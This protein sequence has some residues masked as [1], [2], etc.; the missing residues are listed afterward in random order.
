V[1]KQQRHTQLKRKIAKP[2]GQTEVPIPGGGRL[3]VKKGNTAIEIERSPNPGR[4]RAALKRLRNQ[5]NARKELR[6]PQPN[7]DA[8]V[9]IA[10]QAGVKLT[11][12]NLSGTKRRTAGQ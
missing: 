1:K 6:V 2:G 3:D 11:V 9:E 12:T 7:L 5:P 4:I 8:A 10:K